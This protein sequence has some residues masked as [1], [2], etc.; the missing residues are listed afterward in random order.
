MK[1]AL[2]PVVVY[3]EDGEIVVEV[4]EKLTGRKRA[5]AIMD[6][7]RAHE[8][9]LGS[10][11]VLPLMVYAWE[12][13]KA[14]ARNHPAAATA[15]TAAGVVVIGAAI[16]L[17]TLHDDGSAAPVVAAPT[18]TVVATVTAVP[19]TTPSGRKPTPKA[20]VTSPRVNT[21]PAPDDVKPASTPQPTPMPTPTGSIPPTNRPPIKTSPSTEI[22]EIFASVAPLNPTQAATALPTE[23]VSP[24]AITPAPESVSVAAPDRDCLLRL[25]LEPLLDACVG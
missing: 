6:A 3:E 4:D 2:L 25:D 14:A 15:A 22:V 20:T 17:P 23:I 13:V 9:G 19:T 24:P 7:I 1:D 10:V 18:H 5:S 16:A 11:V 8:R 21:T 12:P